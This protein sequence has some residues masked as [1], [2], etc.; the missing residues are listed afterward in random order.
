MNSLLRSEL[1]GHNDMVIHRESFDGK[2]SSPSRDSSSSNQNM[3]KYRF[4]VGSTASSI[5]SNLSLSG[6]SN[7]GDLN[8]GFISS[9]SASHSAIKT[10]K[11]NRKIPKNPFK[12]LDAPSLQDDYYLNLIDWSHNNVIAVALGSSV[13]LWSACTSKVLI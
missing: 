12:V 11:P 10:S 2:I 7:V 3:F 1:L 9:S 8:S 4:S 5:D 6:N 13:Y